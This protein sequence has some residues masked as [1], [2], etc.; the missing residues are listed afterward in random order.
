MGAVL[1]EYIKDLFAGTINKSDVNKRNQKMSEFCCYLGN[2]HTFPESMLKNGGD[3]IDVKK[4]D[5]FN[6]TIAINSIYPKAKLYS[7][8]EM[9]N[10][11][12]WLCKPWEVRDMLYV[13]RVLSG[14][15]LTSLTL[16]FGDEYCAGKKI[17]ECIMKKLKEGILS[18]PNVEFAFTMKLGM[19]NRVAPL[20][21]TV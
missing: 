11:A 3:A 12:C 8:I 18:I 10:R 5:S 17:Y 16:V 9:I 20:G 2:Q 19:V 6:S 1:E 21:I 4:I 14:E 15:M 7:N 13:V